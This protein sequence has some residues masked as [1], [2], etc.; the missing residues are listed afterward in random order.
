MQPG[1]KEVY[2]RAVIRGHHSGRGRRRG[3]G[4]FMHVMLVMIIEEKR[5]IPVFLQLLIYQ[6][7]MLLESLV[8][9]RLCIL[10]VVGGASIVDTALRSLRS[11]WT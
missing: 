8:R 6:L 3:I 10:K 2:V 5:G 1:D 9:L 7:L 4:S 11:I